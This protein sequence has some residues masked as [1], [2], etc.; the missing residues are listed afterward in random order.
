MYILVHIYVLYVM[1][2][3]IFVHLSRVSRSI[4]QGNQLVPYQHTTTN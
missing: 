3:N 1:L 2:N 4:A